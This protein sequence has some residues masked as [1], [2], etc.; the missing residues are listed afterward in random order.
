[1]PLQVDHARM[2]IQDLKREDTL[3]LYK[4]IFKIS[5]SNGCLDPNDLFNVTLIQQIF[6]EYLLCPRY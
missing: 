2:K 5:V 3:Q 4:T 6:T 1:M